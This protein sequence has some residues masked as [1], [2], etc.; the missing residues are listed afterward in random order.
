MTAASAPRV[1][2]IVPAYNAAAF[3][4]QALD[5][6]LAQRFVDFEV[7]VVDDG[8]TDQTGR[9]ADD[10]ARRDP[11]IRV[12]HQRNRGLPAARNTAIQVGR[13]EL[14]ALLDADDE[15]LPD[16]LALAVAAFDADPG[17]GLL[18]ANIERIDEAGEL[19]WVCGPR[20][21]GAGDPYTALA[22]RLEHVSC[23]TA[24]FAR[25]C[26]EAVGDFDLQFT[27]LGCEDRDLWLRIIERFPVRYLD[28]VT[29]RYRMHGGSMSANFGKMA[30]ARL[31]L[32]DKLRES[33]R[34]ALIADHVAAMI[35]SDRGI[36]ALDA[37]RA[38]DALRAQWR[39]LRLRP[40]SLLLWRRMFGLLRRCAFPLA[41]GGPVLGRPQ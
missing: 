22:L 20:W 34:G 41:G 19:L 29:A 36:E 33:P 6:A 39:A 3:L 28:V 40:Q 35:E 27:G 15:W 11:R 26:I 18:H 37:G 10:Y 5:S 25:R 16:H 12:V 1:T 14:Y 30:R 17:L 7:V 21:R 31:R 8:S 32:L 4:P 9:I 2:V 38:G 24:V 23:P 13:G